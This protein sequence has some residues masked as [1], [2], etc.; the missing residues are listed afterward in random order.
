MLRP[1]HTFFKVLF[2]GKN[3]FIVL[4]SLLLWILQTMGKKDMVEVYS[5]LSNRNCNA[6]SAAYQDRHS[7]RQTPKLRLKTIKLYKIV[8]H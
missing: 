7:N 3:I 5:T 1:F 8:Q 6:A 2:E 4:V